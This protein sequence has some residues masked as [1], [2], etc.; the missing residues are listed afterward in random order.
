MGWTLETAAVQTKSSLPL[1]HKV[2]P[3]PV[4]VAG[5]APTSGRSPLCADTRRRD[6]FAGGPAG[7]DGR[8]RHHAARGRRPDRLVARSLLEP[9]GGTFRT[10]MDRARRRRYQDGR[11]EPSGSSMT[12]AS[13]T[14]TTWA[15]T[16]FDWSDTVRFFPDDCL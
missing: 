4:H 11:V 9:L 8:G 6:R 15:V 16:N 1:P 10:R 2:P 14:T 5:P 3:A 7:H 13:T 12:G